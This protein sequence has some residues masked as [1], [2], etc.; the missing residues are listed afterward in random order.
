MEYN[1]G[2]TITRGSVRESLEIRTK[3]RS[4]D[5]SSHFRKQLSKAVGSLDHLWIVLRRAL[6]VHDS[7]QGPL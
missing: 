3:Q 2:D 4:M 6:R 5:Y 1:G 7:A